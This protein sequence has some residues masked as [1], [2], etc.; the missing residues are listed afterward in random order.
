MFR[1]EI[2]SRDTILEISTDVIPD[3]IELDPNRWLLA[4]INY[5]RRMSEFF[6]HLHILTFVHNILK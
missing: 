3:S 4:D 1:Y 2:M 6:F 5:E